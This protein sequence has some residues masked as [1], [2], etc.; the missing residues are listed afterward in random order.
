VTVPLWL[1]IATVWLALLLGFLFGAGWANA[2][3]EY[4]ADAGRGMSK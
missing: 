1:L 4:E 3:R 2:V